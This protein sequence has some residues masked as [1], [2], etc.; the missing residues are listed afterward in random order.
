MYTESFLL[1]YEIFGCEQT[2][3]VVIKGRGG[4][5]TRDPLSLVYEQ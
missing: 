3:C 5:V 2:K 4:G 1:F